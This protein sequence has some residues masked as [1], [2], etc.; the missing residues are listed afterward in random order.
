MPMTLQLDGDD[1]PL[2]R[3]HG[4]KLPPHTCSL[5]AARK[6]HQRLAA[7]VDFI[8]QIEAVHRCVAA[9][10]G[11]LSSLVH[12]MSFLF[13]CVPVSGNKLLGVAELGDDVGNPPVA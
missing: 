4:Q 13:Y 10:G 2:L 7:A 9:Y 8:I 3:Q 1:L 11:P 12:R 6:Q 5:K